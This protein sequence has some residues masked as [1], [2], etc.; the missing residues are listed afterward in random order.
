MKKYLMMGAAALTMGF[1]FVSCSSDDVVYNPD[2]AQNQIVANY[3]KAFIKTFGQPAANHTWGF[4]AASRATRGVYANNNQWG[5]PS[6]G[7][8]DIP[9]VLTQGQ[10]DRAAAY[11]RANPRLTYVDPGYTDFFVQ[12]V[13]TG[14]A[15]YTMG[16]NGTVTGSAQMDKLSFGTTTVTTVDKFNNGSFGGAVNVC[17]SGASTNDC[18]NDNTKD[19]TWHLDEI[20]L[21]TNDNTSSVGYHGSEAAFHH[22]TGRCALV[23]ASVIDEWAKNPANYVD[24]QVIGEDCV[25]GWNRSFVGLD[26]DGLSLQDAMTTTVAKVENAP[27]YAWVWTGTELKKWD[28][29]K[30]TTLKAK[31]GTSDLY[32]I[33]SNTNQFIGAAND[34]LSDDALA[35]AMSKADF[36]EYSKTTTNKQE[37][38]VLDLTKIQARINDGY[39]PVQNGGLKKWSRYDGRDYYYSDWIVTLTRAYKIG[40]RPTPVVQPSLRVMA[41]DLSADD[42]SDFDF[43]DVVFK[44]TR[45]DDTQASITLEAAGGTLPLRINSTDG[46]GGWEVHELFGVDVKTMVNTKAQD[47]GLKGADKPAVTAFNNEPLIVTGDFTTENFN[48]AVKAIRV[49]VKKVV[50]GEERWLPLEAEVGK[51]A[52][53]FGVPATLD[54]ALERTNVNSAFNFSEWVQNPS[55]TL[56]PAAE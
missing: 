3:Q 37:E 45:I 55:V 44:V 23:A 50:N 34:F 30:N 52:C 42:A 51:A 56:R 15:S 39:L 13:Y 46:V 31:D 20:Q 16:N 49:E 28:D 26:F 19:V 29:I 5:D 54:W 38:K 22:Y 32:F 48:A 7:N 9:P 6:Y 4:G 47:K 41:E 33:T 2:A 25:D 12:Q 17:N 36:E 24:G 10:K 14:T 53:K 1:A 21:L 43:N 35:L 8:Y 18:G 40:E 27:Y 11:F